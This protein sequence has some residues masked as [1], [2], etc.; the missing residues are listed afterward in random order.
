MKQ[1]TLTLYYGSALG[2]IQTLPFDDIEAAIE[3]MNTLGTPEYMGE[4]GYHIMTDRSTMLPARVETKTTYPSTSKKVPNWKHPAFETLRSG[5]FDRSA[6]D[7]PEDNYYP[8]GKVLM[9]MESYSNSQNVELIEVMKDL[10]L[11]VQFHGNDDDISTI[12]KA[13]ALLDKHNA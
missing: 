8:T 5:Q 12:K 9:A 10:L 6:S 3:Y 1:V 13:Q 11:T 4:G 2:G 7:D